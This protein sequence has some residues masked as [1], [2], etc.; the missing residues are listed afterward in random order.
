[1][2]RETLSVVKKIPVMKIPRQFNRVAQ[3]RHQPA[4]LA[5][6]PLL[7]QRAGVATK[8]TLIKREATPTGARTDQTTP[9]S[10][11]A[12]RAETWVRSLRGLRAG[13]GRTWSRRRAV[14]GRC[15]TLRTG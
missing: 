7:A 6:V 13:S 1:M 3:D 2:V 12:G 5:R 9:L 8:S 10:V 14:S 4:A 15:T 11:R